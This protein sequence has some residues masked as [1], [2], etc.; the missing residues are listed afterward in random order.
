MNYRL[1]VRAKDYGEHTEALQVATELATEARIKLSAPEANLEKGAEINM[2]TGDNIQP[3][4]VMTYA[5]Q[6]ESLKLTLQTKANLSAPIGSTILLTCVQQPYCDKKMTVLQYKHPV[7]SVK[8]VLLKSL[9]VE[10][11]LKLTCSNLKLPVTLCQVSFKSNK[12][13]LKLR[14]SF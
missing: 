5:L 4:H 14:K 2:N 12:K 9:F 8:G 6:E 7:L 1:Y 11:R 13:Y 10:K 3:I